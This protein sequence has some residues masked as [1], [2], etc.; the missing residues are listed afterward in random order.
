MRGL[1]P[2][3]LTLRRIVHRSAYFFALFGTAVALSLPQAAAQTCPFD[4]GGSTLANDGLVMT[5]YALGL[6]GANLVANTA[7]AA[8][9]APTIESNITCPSCGLNVT[10]Q[11]D[12][13][14]NPTFTVA[15]ATIISRKIAGFSGAQ[16]TSGLA[17]GSGARSAPAAVQSF[18][19]AGCGVGAL[20]T[21]F[22]GQVATFGPTGALQCG[23]MPATNTDFGTIVG[24]DN[25]IVIPSDGRPLI[26][27]LTL[28]T[29]STVKLAVVKCGNASCS[30]GNTS[31]ALADSS[32]FSSSN[33]GVSMALPSDGLPI[34]SYFD[35]TSKDLRVVKCGNASCTAGNT[36]TSLDT[37]GGT[38][39]GRYSSIAVGADNL[40]IISYFD[41]TNARLKLAKCGNAVCSVATVSV[42]DPAL[43]VGSYTSIAVP[44]DGRPV[45]A[46]STFSGS[47]TGV[48]GLKVLKCLNANCTGTP[49]LTLI[50]SGTNVGDFISLT[51]PADGLPIMS[52]RFINGSVGFVAKVAKCG[53]GACSSGNVLTDVDASTT[54]G[55]YGAYTSI[56]AAADGRPIL[57]HGVSTLR[58]VKCG[59]G[60]CSSGNLASFRPGRGASNTIVVPA[61]GLP[62]IGYD[63]LAAPRSFATM[64]C[65]NAACLSP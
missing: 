20:P 61:D 50:D 54:E 57:V 27:F 51:V 62:L 42:P 18:L 5:R 59:N 33:Y 63:S 8:I 7:F 43:S 9:D 56:A 58:V 44:A 14:S 46:Y 3:F 34:I 24:L 10:G 40:P 38:D 23:T 4:N 32:I 53:N 37:A 36:A 16:L 26:A 2:L 64:K 60:A 12:G 1:T 35:N 21:C 39:V 13:A 11:V 48:T 30:A 15:D 29:A 25:A 41:R 65:S 17:L 47:E 52:Y 45:V 6:R 31:A 22:T 55:E 49:T 19:L 28:V